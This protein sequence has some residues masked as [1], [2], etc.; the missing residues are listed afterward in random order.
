MKDATLG[1]K[2]NKATECDDIPTEASRMAVTNDEGTEILM[3]L[4]NLIENKKVSKRKKTVLI[5]PLYKRK[6]NQ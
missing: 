4:F 1:I 2:N 5:Q 3:K 6:G